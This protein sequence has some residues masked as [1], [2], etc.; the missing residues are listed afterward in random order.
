MFVQHE[1]R[2][3]SAAETLQETG[4]P[5]NLGA[6]SSEKEYNLRDHDAPQVV[7]HSTA[8]QVGY[9]H[10]TFSP[11]IALDREYQD[12]AYPEVVYARYGSPP[13][14]HTFD[15][16]GYDGREP[17]DGQHPPRGRLRRRTWWIIIAFALIVIL[18]AGL[19]AGLGIGL[20]SKDPAA[21]GWRH[22]QLFILT[23]NLA[24]VPCS[25]L[26]KTPSPLFPSS[27]PNGGYVDIWAGNFSSPTP[28]HYAM[29]WAPTGVRR[30]FTGVTEYILSSA[31][32]AATKG[33][34]AGF[35]YQGEDG[36]TVQ[37]VATEE[38][39]GQGTGV[40]RW[41]AGV[42]V[43]KGG[44]MA[45]GW[46]GGNGGECV[47]M[48]QGGAELRGLRVNRNGRVVGNATFAGGG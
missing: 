19:G 42:G 1:K 35:F 32:D 33:G 12:A 17:A 11:K 48:V 16:R 34:R 27:D 3:L 25:V 22:D 10:D 2:P 43:G 8:P 15:G 21:T 4:Q 37:V 28:L 46:V 31:L 29:D 44:K 9:D 24:G 41:D 20:K 23:A 6:Y 36:G 18:G 47:V 13:V 40:G 45:A 30:N 26:P 14:E 5:H 38:P 39:P 7:D